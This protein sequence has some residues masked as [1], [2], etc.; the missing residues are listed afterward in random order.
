MKYISKLLLI[1]SLTFISLAL[2]AQQN[3]VF[4]GKFLMG[5]V[6]PTPGL[7]DINIAGP[8]VGG[9]FSW[10]ILPLGDDPYQYYWNFPSYGLS[11][12]FIDVSKEVS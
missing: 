12:M 4:K 11:L 8:I 6:L 2:Q 1:S 5:G 10:E 7:S 3:Y 9:E